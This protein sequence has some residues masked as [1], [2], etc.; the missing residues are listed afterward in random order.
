MLKTIFLGK[1]RLFFWLV[2]TCAFLYYRSFGS[3][4]IHP[5]VLVVVSWLIRL[6]CSL[7]CWRDGLSNCLGYLFRFLVYHVLCI[8]H[9][10]FKFQIIFSDT[11]LTSSMSISNRHLGGSLCWNHFLGIYLFVDLSDVLF[12]FIHALILY[13]TFKLRYITSF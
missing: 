6:V 7:D 3:L 9:V 10:F 4:Y 11:E 12:K 2:I 1:T 5:M 13:F 8:I